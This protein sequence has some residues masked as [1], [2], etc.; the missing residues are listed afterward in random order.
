VNSFV[1]VVLAVIAGQHRD[2]IARL[3]KAGQIIGEMG[4]NQLQL[5]D[6]AGG[7]GVVASGVVASYLEEGFEIAARHWGRNQVLLNSLFRFPIARAVKSAIEEK[8][9]ISLSAK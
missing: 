5:A 4:L 7:L 9:L 8:N 6:K 2:L 3:E 1:L